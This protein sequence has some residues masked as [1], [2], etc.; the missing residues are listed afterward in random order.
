MSK[1][2]NHASKRIRQRLGLPKK[3][4]EKLVKE[5][6]EQGLRREDTTAQLRK[7]IDSKIIPNGGIGIVYNQRLFIFNS[8]ED[9]LITVWTLPNTLKEIATK[10]QAKDKAPF[11][12][13]LSAWVKLFI[14]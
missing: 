8:T 12:Y 3:A 14:L 7:Y 9:T 13:N 1:A 2:S 11:T 5:A 6:L 10:K 4:V